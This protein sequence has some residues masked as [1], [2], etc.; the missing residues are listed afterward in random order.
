K[1]VKK[2]RADGKLTPIYAQ[3][4]KAP[5]PCCF[6]SFPYCYYGPLR[7]PAGRPF[8][9]LLLPIPIIFKKLGLPAALLPF[10]IP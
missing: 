4:R 3:R 8:L 9:S 10:S 6:S 2:V 5:P 1:V 7:R